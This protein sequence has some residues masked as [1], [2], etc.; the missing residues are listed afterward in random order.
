MA[1]NG[2][3][4]R[5]GGAGI[6]R[7]PRVGERGGGGVG[8]ITQPGF[9]RVLE[10]ALHQADPCF[11]TLGS[12]LKWAPLSGKPSRPCQRCIQ[13]GLSREQ[14]LHWRDDCPHWIG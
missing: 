3:V 8:A 2:V 1:P 6:R 11:K 12:N 5:R 10:V 7:N 14:A 4:L 9:Y 13:K